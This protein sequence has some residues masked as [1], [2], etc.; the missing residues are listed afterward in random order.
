MA[1]SA[2]QIEGNNTNNDWWEWEHLIPSKIKNNEKSGIAAD[3]WNKVSEDTKLLNELGVKQ[4]RFSIEWSRIEPKKGFFSQE[5]MD[6][7]KNE[8]RELKK[9]N[10]A[11]MVTL[12]HF[13]SPLWF[14]KEGGWASPE[15]P[16]FFLDF[17]K[18][19]NQNLGTE[20]DQ[21]ITFNEPMVMIAGGYVNGVFPPGIAD[22]SK[23]YNPIK[24][25]LIAHSL[26]YKELHRTSSK[27]LV[28]IA[29][30]LR[31]MEPYNKLNP[32]EWYLA[33]KLSKAFNWTF[34]NTIKT[35]EL[36]LSIPTKV[37]FTESLPEAKGTQDFIGINYYSRDLVQYTPGKKNVITLVTNKKNEQSDLGWE[38]YPRGLYDILKQVNKE[39]NNTPIYLTE[40]GIADSIDSRRNSFLTQ[41]L[42]QIH[43]ALQD[44]VNIQGYCHWSLIDNFEWAEGFEPRFG[45]YKVDYETLKR[46][47]RPSALLYQDIITRN[48]FLNDETI[49][50]ESE[51]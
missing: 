33:K 15:S 39:F 40:N 17:V 45:L 42:K 4:Y 41:H 1:T 22:W 30:H 36:S 31:I 12:H 20:V 13:T 2:H 16:K 27:A 38:I 18:F 23:I 51:E 14:A 6:H 43:R 49:N 3:H 10:I 32:I 9:Y 25:I 5:A 28:G 48:G 7:Y 24:N 19:V 35:G 26:A 46:T 37:K 47:P 11:P 50:K 44:G 8:I 34:L 29:H 21:W